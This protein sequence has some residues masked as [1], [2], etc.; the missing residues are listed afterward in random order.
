MF[1]FFHE[2]SR[3]LTP[4]GIHSLIGLMD[5]IK[6]SRAGIYRN[7]VFNM[8]TLVE[9][10]KVICIATTRAYRDPI[11]AMWSFLTY[12]YMLYG[13]KMLQYG[14]VVDYRFAVYLSCKLTHISLGSSLSCNTPWGLSSH[15]VAISDSGFSFIPSLTLSFLIASISF[16]F[17][18]NS[19]R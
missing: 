15:K 12:V 1:C 19:S 2:Q 8:V 3:Y 7:F 10:F 6:G 11:L 9:L 5:T 4:R 17:Q 18:W 16:S 14:Q 13:W